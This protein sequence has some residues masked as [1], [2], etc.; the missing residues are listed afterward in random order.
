MRDLGFTAS[1]I[2]RTRRCDAGRSLVTP[3]TVGGVLYVIEGATLGG[4]GLNR[5][6]TRLL[7]HESPAGRRFWAWCEAESKTRWLLMTR[8]L[9]DLDIGDASTADLETGAGEMFGALAEWLAPLETTSRM[10][11]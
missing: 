5:A 6:A 1:D 4:K 7:S 11:A 3:A 8:Y 9:Q 10:S 2:R